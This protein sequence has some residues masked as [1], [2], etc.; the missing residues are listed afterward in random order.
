MISFRKK[1]KTSKMVVQNWSIEF[2]KQCTVSSDL[3]YVKQKLLCSSNGLITVNKISWGWSNVTSLYYKKLHSTVS[4][5]AQYRKI[6]S[7]QICQST[8][9]KLITVPIKFESTLSRLA[10]FCICLLLK[11]E[12]RQHWH[13]TVRKHNTTTLSLWYKWHRR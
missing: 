10:N 4:K 8:F 11:N 6:T 9:K 13:V 2:T 1:N 12:L 3:T 5:I 7:F